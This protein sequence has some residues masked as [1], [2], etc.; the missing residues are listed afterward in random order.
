MM[1]SKSSLIV[2]LKVNDGP[3][4]KKVDMPSILYTQSRTRTHTQR[5]RERGREREKC[6][7]HKE[8][9]NIMEVLLSPFAASVYS[10]LG[11]EAC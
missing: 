4:S 1:A 11:H 7:H 2:E 6:F 5:K 8:I 9:V 3:A 10:S